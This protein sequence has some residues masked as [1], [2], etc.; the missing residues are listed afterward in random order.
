MGMPRKGLQGE[1]SGREGE[2]GSVPLSLPPLPP[3]G[4]VVAKAGLPELSGVAA[5]EEGRDPVP[6]R[7]QRRYRTA[8]ATPLSVAV[9][10]RSL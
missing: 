7:P 1:N 8:T 2:H 5:S 3:P 9:A 4:V 6:M 10:H